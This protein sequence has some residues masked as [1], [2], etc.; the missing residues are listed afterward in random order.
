VCK[1][2]EGR[3][4]GDDRPATTDFD[5]LGVASVAHDEVIGW[6]IGRLSEKRLTA[7]RRSPTKR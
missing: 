6:W 3:A 2:E 5:L 1:R 7:S 4:L